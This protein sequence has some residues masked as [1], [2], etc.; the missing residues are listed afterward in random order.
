M[1]TYIAIR[2]HR[3]LFLSEWG[4]DISLLKTLTLRGVSVT[5]AINSDLDLNTVLY[6][7]HP[8]GIKMEISIRFSLDLW[9]KTILSLVTA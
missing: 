6:Y 9:M 3:K 8:D 2:S 5:R 7:L 4:I 1:V